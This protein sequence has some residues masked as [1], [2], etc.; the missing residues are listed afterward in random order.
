MGGAPWV[1]KVSGNRVE[2]AVGPQ[3]FGTSS[4]KAVVKA[5]NEVMQQD[6][7]GGKLS[8]YVYYSKA[9]FA[10]LSAAMSSGPAMDSL[11]AILVGSHGGGGG[12]GAK[13]AARQSKN[14]GGGGGGAE[15]AAHQ[16]KK[17]R[18]A[19]KRELQAAHRD[20]GKHGKALF[21]EAMAE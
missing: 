14:G 16:S 13:P 3:V 18:L 4:E 20:L 2:V 7:S 17:E 21:L 15:P 1:I 10:G 9:P 11:D 6:P 8:E 5:A 19:A 12:G